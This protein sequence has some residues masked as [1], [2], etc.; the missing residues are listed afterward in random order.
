MKFILGKKVGMTTI[1][2][3]EGDAIPVTVISAGPCLVTQVRTNENDGYKAIQLGFDEKKKLNKPQ[4]GHLKRTNKNSR[5]L[6][7]CRIGNEEDAKV[8]DVVDVSL[9]TTGDKVK[10][11]GNVKA[12]GFTGAVKRWG[13]KGH[14]G[15]HGHPHERSVGSIGSGYP[16]HVFKGKK[17]AGRKAPFRKT[18]LNLEVA[19][20]DK[21]NNLLLVKG[22]VPGVKGRLL[23]IRG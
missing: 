14:P 17:M 20:V 18:I 22:S 11:A 5:Y 16:Q 23:E 3:Q 19:D 21:E 15:S 8:G 2:N 13:F 6:R 4:T 10:I 12:K 1:I 9:F 7:E